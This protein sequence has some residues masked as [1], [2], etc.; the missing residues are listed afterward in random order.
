MKS[1]Y[2]H[3]QQHLMRENWNLSCFGRG[4]YFFLGFI[5]SAFIGYASL[6]NDHSNIAILVANFGLVCSFAWSFSNRGSKFWYESWEEKV[7]KLEL[8]VTGESNFTTI[9]N[10]LTDKKLLR[11]LWGR[12]RFSV[13]RIAIALSDYTVAIWFIIILIELNQILCI[14]EVKKISAIILS[15]I[16]VCSV[17]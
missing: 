17:I 8:Q 2:S 13:S 1:P 5:S 4:H 14:F 16:S 7:K 3:L 15:V 9:E 11:R 12:K 6:H 10:F